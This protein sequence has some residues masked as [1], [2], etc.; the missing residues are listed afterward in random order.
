MAKLRV[1][2]SMNSEDIR[3]INDEVLSA[4]DRGLKVVIISSPGLNME[5]VTLYYSNKSKGQI[6]I[7]ADSVEVLTGELNDSDTCTCLYSRNQNLVQLIKESLINELKLID[8]TKNN[9]AI[10]YVEHKI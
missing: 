4:R 6:R 3:L 7:I 9:E 8:L 10:D 2:I 1:Y 5:G